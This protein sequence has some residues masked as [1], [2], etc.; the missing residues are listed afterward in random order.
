MLAATLFYRKLLFD[1]LGGQLAPANPQTV[2]GNAFSF[3]VTS[4]LRQWS[5]PNTVATW[6]Y[7]ECSKNTNPDSGK[8]AI[9]WALMRHTAMRN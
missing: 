3:T 5:S 9:Q 2:S 6:E 7:T 4:F 1:V 8:G